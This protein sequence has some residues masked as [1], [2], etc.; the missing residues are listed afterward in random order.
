MGF[1]K[2][3]KQGIED[4]HGRGIEDSPTTPIED[5]VKGGKKAGGRFDQNER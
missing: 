1:K 2:V 5:R 4:R 3:P